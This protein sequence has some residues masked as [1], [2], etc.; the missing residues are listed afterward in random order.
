VEDAEKILHVGVG[1]RMCV[2]GTIGTWAWRLDVLE[3]NRFLKGDVSV[4]D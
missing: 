4:I 3:D 2:T 1:K